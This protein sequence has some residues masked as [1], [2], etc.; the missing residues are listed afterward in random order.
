MTSKRRH[1]RDTVPAQLIGV[2]ADA[3][4]IGATSFRLQP[5]PPYIM[6]SISAG[7]RAMEIDFESGSGE[8]MIEFLL[9]QICDRKHKMGGFVMDYADKLYPCEVTA[10][11]VRSPQWIELSWTCS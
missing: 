9:S 7:M 4:R 10:D 2:F 6:A 1:K 3:V 5:N 8:E 11:R